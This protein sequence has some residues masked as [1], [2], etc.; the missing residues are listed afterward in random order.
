MELHSDVGSQ[1]NKGILTDRIL[2]FLTELY[3]KR[4]CQKINAAVNCESLP[5]D[6]ASIVFGSQRQA[7]IE[8][9]IPIGEHCPTRSYEA[10][11]RRQRLARGYNPPDHKPN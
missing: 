8:C 4:R 11:S 6:K 7:G 2:G 3:I 1:K 9:Y 5:K 10:R